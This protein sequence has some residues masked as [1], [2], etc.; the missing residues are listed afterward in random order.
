VIQSVPG[1][2]EKRITRPSNPAFR[3]NWLVRTIDIGDR[4]PVASAIIVFFV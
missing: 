4:L 3:G 1:L 2:I